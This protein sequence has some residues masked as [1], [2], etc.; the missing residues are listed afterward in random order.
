[1]AAEQQ[2]LEDRLYERDFY[3]WTQEQGAKL[4]RRSFEAIDWEN[5][6][7]EI[8][9]VGRRERRDIRDRLET[10]LKLLLKWEFQPDLRCHSWQSGVSE[11]RTFIEGT[12]EMSPSLAEFPGQALQD[13]YNSARERVAIET[14]LPTSTFPEEVP[15]S[16]VE[17][18]NFRFMPGRPWSPDELRGD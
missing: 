9:S 8:E 14:G 3:V 4:R 16:V 1:M 6:A 11:Q 12:L 17:A 15:F 2:K 18:L 5:L 13:E 7:E 10:L